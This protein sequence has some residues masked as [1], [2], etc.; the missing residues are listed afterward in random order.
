MENVKL[1]KNKQYCSTFFQKQKKNIV[2]YLHVLR[3]S[4]S[5]LI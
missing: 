3:K 5:S 4:L 2:L 1:C